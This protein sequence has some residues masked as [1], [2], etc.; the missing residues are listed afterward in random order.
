MDGSVKVDFCRKR[1]DKKHRRK[2]SLIENENEIKM[3]KI[4]LLLGSHVVKLCSCHE[5]PV[6][7]T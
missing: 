5:D 6:F 4:T 2:R 7:I 3:L 1:N